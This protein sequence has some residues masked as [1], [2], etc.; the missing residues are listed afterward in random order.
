VPDDVGT[1]DTER[2]EDGDHVGDAS[3]DRIVLDRSRLVGLAEAAEV[4]CDHAHACAGER[5]CLVPP[6]VGRVGEAVEQQHGP[7]L[8]LVE[9]R[10][11][12][13]VARDVAHRAPP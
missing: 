10:Q 8:T 12:H 7:A 6:Q 3:C 5:R 1:L 2:V 4:G 11:V 13:S 9:Y